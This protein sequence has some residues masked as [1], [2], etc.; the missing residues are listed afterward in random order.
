MSVVVAIS[1]GLGMAYLAYS[2]THKLKNQNLDDI[3]FDSSIIT[4]NP[5]SGSTI[6]VGEKVTAT[7]RYKCDAP[8]K[9]E[10]SVW[11][12]I[13]E[14][15]PST[16]EPSFD[17][18]TVGKGQFHRWV[19]LSTEGEI[20]SLRVAVQTHRHHQVVYKNCFPVSYKVIEN[21]NLNYLKNDG[22]DSRILGLSFKP[23]DSRQIKL[24]T[25]IVATLDYD[26]KSLKG[27]TV[28][29][30]PEAFDGGSGTYQSSGRFLNG[31]GQ[32]KRYFNMGNAR[33]LEA[34]IV[35]MYNQAHELVLEERHIVN[36]E[37]VD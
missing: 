34:V 17:E 9:Q 27:L 12:M 36:Y 35:S 4:L 16:Y 24:G 37:F 6:R 11:V 18:I 19:S 10:F 25:D 33:Y 3:K 15:L 32:V 29:I 21:E 14:D 20:N 23:S 1:F 30:I 7:I 26:I 28:Y 31:R 2:K 13:D 5:P 22:V 8:I